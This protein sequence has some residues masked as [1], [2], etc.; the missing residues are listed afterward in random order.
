MSN[1]N[2][3]NDESMFEQHRQRLCYLE[4]WRELAVRPM[5]FECH[6]ED[7]DLMRA[8]QDD[9]EVLMNRCLEARERMNDSLPPHELAM[10]NDLC[11]DKSA[12]ENAGEGLFFRPSSS[13]RLIQKGD[14]LCYYCG[15]IHNFH[16]SKRLK[17][18]SYLMLV[19]NDVF[20][21]PGPLRNIKARYINDPLN[22]EFWNCK[23]VPQ[24][25]FDRCAVVATRDIVP[26]EELFV[27]YGESYWANQ[28]CEG[29]VYNGKKG[30]AS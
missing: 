19:L 14:I 15:H 8:Q 18:K 21:D 12:I 27:S 5:H 3:N 29:T 23:F 11:P 9:C 25:E 16:S 26:G 28:D 13:R 6:E 17:D 30:K 4:K 1:P 10:D 24:P 22:E 2:N 20:V 7:M